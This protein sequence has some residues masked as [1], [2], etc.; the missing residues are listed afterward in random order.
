MDSPPTRIQTLVYLVRSGEWCRLVCGML[1][2]IMLV[3]EK[4]RKRRTGRKVNMRFVSYD[5]TYGCYITQK[6]KVV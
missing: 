2:G 4:E 5:N 6:V 3:I 1:C